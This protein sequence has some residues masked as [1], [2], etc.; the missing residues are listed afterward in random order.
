M[1]GTASVG[2]NQKNTISPRRYINYDFPQ[3]GIW[4]KTTMGFYGS[5]E[6]I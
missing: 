5:W 4:H 1:E 3:E 6:S 2:K